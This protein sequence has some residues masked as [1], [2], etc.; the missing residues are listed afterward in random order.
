VIFGGVGWAVSLLAFA[1]SKSYYFSLALAFVS[2]ITQDIS[3][4]LIAMLILAN[5]AEPMRGRV[6]GLRTGVI[7]SLPFGNL[8]AGAAAERLGAPLAQAAYAASAL[9]LMLVIVA[10]VPN[11]RKLD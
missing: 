3:W 4:T 10:L 8:F 2:G 5:T 7:V 6:M 9:V 1:A 11:L